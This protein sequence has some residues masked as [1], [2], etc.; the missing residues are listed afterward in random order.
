MV[1]GFASLV[2]SKLFETQSPSGPGLALSALSLISC[3]TLAAVSL[4][5][6]KTILFDAISTSLFWFFLV[7]VLNVV[8]LLV[9]EVE[10]SLSDKNSVNVQDKYLIIHSF[11]SHTYT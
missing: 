1:D 2:D 5:R 11:P 8:L 6:F 3:D 7:S 9:A 10:L 4:L